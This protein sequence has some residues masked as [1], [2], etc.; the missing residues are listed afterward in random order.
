M[1]TNKIFSLAVLALLTAA[2]SSDIAP[3]QQGSRVI[4]FTAT[5]SAGTA[6]T[7]GIEEEDDRLVTYWEK[8]EKVALIHDGV[9]DVMEVTD[10]DDKTG[11]ATISG[12][13]TGDPQDGDDVTVIY[14]AS[15]VDGKT[16]DVK[17]DLLK[18]QDG[19]KGTISQQ[20]DLRQSIDAT[21]KV[22]GNSATL[23][24]TVTL[25]NQI[26]I[27]KF[28]LSDGT[29][30]IATKQFVMTD[31]DDK[32][33][34]KVSTATELSDFYVAMA[35]VN[36]ATFKFSATVGDDIYTY[37]NNNVTIEAGKYYKSTVA[38]NAPEPP[39]P[40]VPTKQDGEIAFT[41]AAPSQTW[42][43]TATDNTYTQTITNTGDA[44]PTYSI[45]D[46][47]CG[48]SI[49]ASTGKVTFTKAGSVTVTATVADTDNYTYATKSVSYTLTVNKAAA[50]I[51]YAT[52]SIN[53][54]TTDE[55]FTY[56][57]TNTG[58]GAV[59]YLSDNQSVATVSSTGEVTIVG[60]GEASITA[61]VADSDTYT[62]ATNSATYKVT[63]T[64]A[65][66][67]INNPGGYAEGGDPTASN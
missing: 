6:P 57:L 19:D 67:L 14:P 25:A 31:G 39:E 3:E 20:F 8:K 24:G 7:R 60:V 64:A 51:S 37:L 38:M 9:M 18:E 26:A 46:N 62:Y 49:D 52:E 35:P 16:L 47:T 42:S 27:V 17:D 4:P 48:A 13:L 66:S 45:S 41:T 56:A 12:N 11:A 15:A 36:N 29:S 28:S 22:S 34:T 30:S 5:L 55:A 2:C 58:D 59:T 61:T 53:K 63:V 23:N 1:K 50:S 65:P 33:I 54:L 32:E 44:V 40:P 10:V 21:L 43:A